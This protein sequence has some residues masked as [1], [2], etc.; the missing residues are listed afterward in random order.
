MSIIALNH[1]LNEALTHCTREDAVKLMGIDVGFSTTRATTA[2]ALL[3]EQKWKGRVLTLDIHAVV[4]V[5][6][7]SMSKVITHPLLVRPSSTTRGLIG[8]VPTR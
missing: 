4:L 5:A 3:D 2:I 7:K 6:Q 8:V 1:A